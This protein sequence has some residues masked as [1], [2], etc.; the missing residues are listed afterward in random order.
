M[1]NCILNNQFARGA[2]AVSVV[3]GSA[4]VVAGFAALLLL[5]AAVK[6]VGTALLAPVLLTKAFIQMPQK[7]WSCGSVWDHMKG[8][9]LVIDALIYGSSKKEYHPID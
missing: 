8:D 1:D 5:A 7:E 9:Y 2:I 3:V 4:V 6:L